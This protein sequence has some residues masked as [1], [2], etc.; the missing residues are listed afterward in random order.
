M[1]DTKIDVRVDAIRY[2]TADTRIVELVR[3]D[4]QPLPNAAA[5]C[6]IDVHL[7]RGLLRQYS[8]IEPGIAPLR[9][10]IGVKKAVGGRGGSAHIVDEL[11]VGTMISISAPRNNFPLASGASPSILIAGG[12][13]ITPILAMAS[14]LTLD[15]AQWQMFYASRS[16]ADAVLLER[17]SAF[18][19]ARL[20]FDDENDG[21]VLDIATIAASAA[22]DTHFYCCG[23]GPM[24]NNFTET[25]KDWPSEQ[26]HFEYF[27]AP[28]IAPAG[29][30]FAVELAREGSVFDVPEGK[31]I[32]QVLIDNGINVPFSCEEGIC[33][34][35]ET[36]VIEGTPD[37]RDLVL[38]NAE[39]ESGNTMMICCSGAKSQRLVL[40]L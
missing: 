40:D 15:G 27:S 7:S 12:I 29:G 19:T 9:Y 10:M 2:A 16:R 37:H 17:V 5:G 20:H 13:G 21:R 6:H 4:H 38:T 3:P 28:E 36:R 24:L 1:I 30:G 39:R 18:E 34:A 26:V 31:T 23:P 14:Q 32:L 22:P 11:K 8:L 35:C 25:L 33:G